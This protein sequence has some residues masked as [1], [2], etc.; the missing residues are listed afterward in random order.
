MKVLMKIFQIILNALIC[1]ITICLLFA[2]YN[3]IQI[4]FLGKD[5]TNFFGYAFFE[6][7]T[8]SMEDTL[9]VNDYVLVKLNDKVNKDDIVTFYYNDSIVTHRIIELDEEKI[10]TKGDANNTFDDPIKH[11][12]LIGRVVYVGKEYGTYIKVLKNPLVIGLVLA[13]IILLS[14]FFDDN[15]KGVKISDEKKE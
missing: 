13:I 1:I 15:G 10:I 8:G 12:D 6:V 3:F 9:Y 5:F 14:I 11:S 7:K 2:L 4:K